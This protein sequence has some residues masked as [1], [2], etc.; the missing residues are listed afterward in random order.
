MSEI[1][2][3]VFGGGSVG[4]CLAANFAKA[5][6]RVFL[7]VRQS[8][9]ETIRGNPIAVSGLL[10]DHVIP[11][12]AYTVCNAAAPTDEVLDCDM[13]IMTTKA[14]DLEMALS[15]FAKKRTLPDDLA[16]PKRNGRSRDC[17]QSGRRG[18]VSLFKRHD[19]WHGPAV[20]D[21]CGCDGS[22]NSYS[23]WRSS[24]RL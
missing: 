12:K 1:S 2:V 18:R 11:A 21:Q 3:A 5:G 16:A 19:D 22:I 13:L 4:L 9:L 20:S 6:A 17:S 8:S 24:G 23:L 7:L 14:Y 15:P 10:G